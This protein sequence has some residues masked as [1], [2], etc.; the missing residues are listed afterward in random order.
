MGRS[1]CEEAGND[2]E[3]AACA[4][5]RKGRCC[6]GAA[7]V[8]YVADAQAEEGE[9]DGADEKEEQQGRAEDGKKYEERED[10]PAL[11]RAVSSLVR[12]K[13]ISAYED[14]E[15]K[16]DIEVTRCAVCHF[17]P[18]KAGYQCN[19]DANPEATIA[20]KGPA[21]KSVTEGDLPSKGYS[22]AAE[23]TRG[24]ATWTLNSS[25]PSLATHHIPPNN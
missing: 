2:A 15:A 7:R 4:L 9:I 8:A 14:E 12:T 11:A 25:E 18:E 3:A 6:F 20:G 19:G 10:K 5:P 24:T 23:R 16:D 17:N 13:Q 1:P 21:T 22:L